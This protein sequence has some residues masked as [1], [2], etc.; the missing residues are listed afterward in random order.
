MIARSLCDIKVV[1]ADE[2]NG[3][4]TSEEEREEGRRKERKSS[5]DINYSIEGGASGAYVTSR[6]AITRD[7]SPSLL[8]PGPFHK[9]QLK[10]IS[11]PS[12][13]WSVAD[14]Y[15]SQLMNA[16]MLLSCD[17]PLSVVKYLFFQ[18][19]KWDFELAGARAR[20]NFNGRRVVSESQW[21]T[22]TFH[23][24]HNREEKNAKDKCDV[25]LVGR[26]YRENWQLRRDSL[27][28]SRGFSIH[29][30]ACAC[31]WCGDRK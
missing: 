15:A 14:Q 10:S 29:V 5:R 6:R 20:A 4:E 8:L 30:C 24:L 19:S 26:P 31:A 28:R 2:S 27:G 25:Q 18:V 1:G 23:F 11:L 17:R 9:P 12:H 7:S 22:R 13:S 21:T 3:A 16:N